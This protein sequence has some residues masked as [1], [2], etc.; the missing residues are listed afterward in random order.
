MGV[1]KWAVYRCQVCGEKMVWIKLPRQKK[2]RWNH[3]Y[4]WAYTITKDCD[5]GI[6]KWDGTDGRLPIETVEVF[7]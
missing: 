7:P 3:L 4:P 6:G 1:K 5:Q 2:A